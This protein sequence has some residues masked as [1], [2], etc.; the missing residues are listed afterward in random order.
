[1]R[2]EEINTLLQDRLLANKLKSKGHTCRQIAN[3]LDWSLCFVHNALKL[4][5]SYDDR[6]KSIKK[7]SA[8]IKRVPLMSLIDQT[9][10]DIKNEVSSRT[11]RKRLQGSKSSWK[12]SQQYSLFATSS[13]F[14]KQV[15]DIS[16]EFLYLLGLMCLLRPVSY[17]LPKLKR[18]FFSF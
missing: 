14:K 9:S 16:V 5:K 11:I 3:C 1:M 10:G 13:S 12:N 6:G 7:I 18:H 17:I 15:S 2:W 4:Q 8:T